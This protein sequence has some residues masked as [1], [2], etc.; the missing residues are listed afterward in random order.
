MRINKSKLLN[1]CKPLLLALLLVAVTALGINV[2]YADANPSVTNPKNSHEA[3]AIRDPK[4]DPNLPPA[5]RA[6]VQR[7]ASINK[8]HEVKKFIQKMVEGE[9]AGSSGKKEGGGD[10]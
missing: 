3:Y 6:R 8:R 9:Q 10:K 4:V 7:D 2:S 1:R 5:A